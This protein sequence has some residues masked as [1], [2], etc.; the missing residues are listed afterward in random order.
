MVC[1][2]IRKFSNCNLLSADCRSSRSEDATNVARTLIDLFHKERGGKGVWKAIT[3]SAQVRVTK[4]VGKRI[5]V[6]IKSSVKFSRSDLKLRLIDLSAGY[7]RDGQ[8]SFES[9]SLKDNEWGGETAD[10]ELKLFTLAK[11]LIFH[12]DIRTD[13]GSLVSRS[14]WFGTHNSGK[15]RYLA[16]IELI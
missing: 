2:K 16:S 14:V 8:F 6:V 13:N 4:N 7:E 11:K 15:Q 5:K 9:S 12:S 10:M 1:N 3:Q